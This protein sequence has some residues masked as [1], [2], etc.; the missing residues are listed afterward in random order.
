MT[1][2]HEIS[3]EIGSRESTVWR[4]DPR[5]M[6][7]SPLEGLI[8]KILEGGQFTGRFKHSKSMAQSARRV[9]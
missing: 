1:H 8:Q 6:S 5:Q 7:A 9:N 3:R 4:D 2:A